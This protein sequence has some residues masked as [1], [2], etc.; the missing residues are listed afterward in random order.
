[1]GLG[2]AGQGMGLKWEID[3]CYLVQV[4]FCGSCSCRLWLDLP[5]SLRLSCIHSPCCLGC[6]LLL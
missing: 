5:V 6:S 4:P 2:L 1:M 3:N